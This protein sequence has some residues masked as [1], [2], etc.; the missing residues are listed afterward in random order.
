[1]KPY[2][3]IKFLLPVIYNAILIPVILGMGIVMIGMNGATE[4]TCT[5]FC[6]FCMAMAPTVMG[7]FRAA[8]LFSPVMFILCLVLSLLWR[9]TEYAPKYRNLPLIL[10]IA[11]QGIFMIALILSVI[12][13]QS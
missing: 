3:K 6:S 5:G 12:A 10:T 7:L 9:N 8:L 11:V 4:E 2:L 1:M 13:A